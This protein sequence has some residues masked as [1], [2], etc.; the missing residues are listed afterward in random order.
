MHDRM[1]MRPFMRYNFG[2][3]LQHWIDLNQE[4]R[5]VP[6]IHHVNWFRKD[7]NNKFLWPGFG[8]NIRVIDWIIRRLDG[9]PDL[10]VGTHIGIDP[11]RAR[12][13]SMVFLKCTG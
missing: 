13:T 9:E 7:A 1:A 2:H 12:S 8:D 3:Y 6:G 11:R 10:G 5:K 4:G